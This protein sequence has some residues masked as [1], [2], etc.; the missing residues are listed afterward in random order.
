LAKDKT[1]FY[2]IYGL[3]ILLFIEIVLRVCYPIPEIQNFNRINYQILDGEQ[4]PT[5]YLRNIKMLWKS[6]PDTNYAFIHELNTY[7]YRDKEWKEKKSAHKRVFILGDSF[8]EGMMTTNDKTIPVGFENGASKDGKSIEVFNC[9]MMGIGLNE[10]IKFITDAVPIFKPDELILVMYSNDMPFQ[11]AYQP[12]TVIT[13]KKNNYFKPRLLELIGR[14]RASD[15]IPLQFMKEE[16]P[17]YKGVPDKSN[18]WTFNEAELA[19]HVRP[20]IAEAMKAGDFNNFRTNWYPNEKNFFSSQIDV[21]SKFQFIKNYLDKNNCK[22]TV[23][24]IPSRLQVSD[25]YYQFEKT[26]CQINCPETSS[27]MGEEYQIHAQILGDICKTNGIKY[28]D[29]TPIIRAKEDAGQHLY[30]SYD[31]HMRGDSYLMLGEEIYNTWSN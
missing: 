5:E 2:I 23:Y 24:Y 17:F 1:S 19:P 28:Q 6:Y 7:G 4:A 20:D 16:I 27:L 30:W 26:Y 22:L 29:L 10:Y 13:P 12:T 11:R 8:V 25:Y 31:D 21:N 15:P 9:G 14:I 3:A 18:P